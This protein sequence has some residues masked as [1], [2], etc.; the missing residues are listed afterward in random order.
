VERVLLAD[1]GKP[2]TRLDLS[3]EGQGTVLLTVSDVID[4]LIVALEG[5]KAEIKL[6]G[7]TAHLLNDPVNAA[8]ARPPLEPEKI[9]DK[10]PQTGDELLAEWEKHAPELVKSMKDGTYLGDGVGH[11][12]G[13]TL[14]SVGR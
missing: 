4:R 7:T 6:S 11:V 2:A 14:L 12:E 1:D 8:N 13:A 3:A 10:P 9:G 5:S